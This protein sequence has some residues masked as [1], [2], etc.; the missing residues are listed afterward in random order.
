MKEKTFKKGVKKR[1]LSIVLALVMM[2]TLIP[3]SSRIAYAASFSKTEISNPTLYESGCLKT[4]DV[5]IQAINEG[6][7][8]AYGK[9]GVHK[10]YSSYSWNNKYIESRDCTAWPETIEDPTMVGLSTTEFL[11]TDC[12]EHTVTVQFEDGKIP[13]DQEK[14]YI[15][16]L[17]TRAQIIG[18]YPDYTFGALKTKADGKLSFGDKEIV[19]KKETSKTVLTVSGVF[20]DKESYT[21][22]DTVGYTGTV[23]MKNG[24]EPVTGIIPEYTYYAKNEESW[25][26][27]N[28][29]PTAAGDYKLVVSVPE[30]NEDYEGK[31]E[32]LFSIAKKPVTAPGANT[33]TFTYTGSEQSYMTIAEAA[34]YKL[35]SDSAAVSQTN[36]GSY[37]INLELK[38][39]ANY[40]WAEGAVTEFAFVINPAVTVKDQNGAV[41]CSGV[42]TKLD[43]S[44][45][46]PEGTTLKPGTYQVV[47]E[48]GNKTIT[49]ILVVEDGTEPTT[50]VNIPTKAVSSKVE[51]KTVADTPKI[52]VGGLD[53]LADSY[54]PGD[55]ESITVTMSVEAKPADPSSAA[56]AA[57]K[58]VNDAQTTKVSKFDFVDMSIIKE[59]FI[60]GTLNN[61]TDIHNAASVLQI[62]VPF[63]TSG[64]KDITVFR[65]HDDGV[66]TPETLIF[67]K[68][69][70]RP[71]TGF[72]DGKFYVGDGF[73]VV[74]A[75]YFSEYAIGYAEEHT[76]HPNIPI[77][78]I[79]AITTPVVIGAGAAATFSAAA[80]ATVIGV[81]LAI[82]AAT[83]IVK[84]VKAEKDSADG[85]EPEIPDTGSVENAAVVPA[86]MIAVMG[87]AV[88][89]L[90][91][92]KKR[93]ENEE[94]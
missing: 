60:N 2:F 1:L 94:E 22:G 34:D 81:P 62:I 16:Y 80:A 83:H 41:V 64:R 79:I 18:I 50:I 26:K 13:C 67:E 49:T 9:I 43:G 48:L 93:K 27:L 86:F 8:P 53:T 88:T 17:W 52:T 56:Q 66:N 7:T 30:D 32:I 38:D 11:W 31:Q 25:T 10:E 15:V 51:I 87:A 58:A 29:A 91:G 21:Y 14:T 42:D 68:L 28:A 5:T 69:D 47:T 85:E 37:T 73:I 12:K 57:I 82:L 74:Y 63:T 3:I 20:M 33:N 84:E 70:V 46:L 77:I 19:V 76:Y 23:S 35:T 6:Y 55:N 75:Q 78:P 65:Y 72:E 71:T 61:T 40:R 39:P 54:T 92:R 4:L 44:Y 90:I 24:E 89:V 59:S 36:A 45:K